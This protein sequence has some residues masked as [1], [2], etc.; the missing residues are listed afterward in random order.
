MP[1]IF[2]FFPTFLV[3]SH[4]VF[5]LRKKNFPSRIEHSI[6]TCVWHQSF[7]GVLSGLHL[8]IHEDTRGVLSGILHLE[9]RPGR[10][11][12]WWPIR[13]PAR[14]TQCTD[15]RV[16]KSNRC[17]LHITYCYTVYYYWAVELSLYACSENIGILTNCKSVNGVPR[18]RRDWAEMCSVVIGNLTRSFSTLID[19]DVGP[20]TI[21]KARAK[22]KIGLKWVYGGPPQVRLLLL[23]RDDPLFWSKFIFSWIKKGESRR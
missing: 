6:L 18:P 14:C 8:E 20:N 7:F 15:V 11:T 12:C 4:V 19:D 9:M 22:D 23:N 17:T 16:F 13:Q 1:Q 21:D 5:V 3:D 2:K 10:C